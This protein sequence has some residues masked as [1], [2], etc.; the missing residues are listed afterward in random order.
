MFQNKL[1]TH[2][3]KALKFEN[4]AD[5]SSKLSHADLTRACEDVV[6]DMIIQDKSSFTNKDVLQMIEERKRSLNK[7][8]ITAQ[9]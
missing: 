6:K 5:A 9:K 4:L 3:E 2:K 7:K 8:D 1:A